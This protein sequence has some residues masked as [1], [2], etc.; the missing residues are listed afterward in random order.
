MVATRMTR[1][2][3][4]FRALLEALE[5]RGLAKNPTAQQVHRACESFVEM[6]ADV[7]QQRVEIRIGNAIIGRSP[8]S[9][10]FG[11]MKKSRG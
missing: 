9:D 5:A 6:V 11:Q 2:L 4:T 8:C 1:L 7:E 3:P 10:A